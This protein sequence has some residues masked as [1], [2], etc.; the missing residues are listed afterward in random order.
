VIK[1]RAF[2]LAV[3][4]AL[5]LGGAAAPAGAQFT[6]PVIIVPPQPPQNLVLPPKPKLPAPKPNAEASP[7]DSPNTTGSGQCYYQGRTRVCP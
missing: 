7:P 3:G 5:A 1:A 4:L 6:Y 2:R